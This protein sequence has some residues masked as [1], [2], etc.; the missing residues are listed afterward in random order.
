[1]RVSGG[2]G[3]TACTGG[4][5]RAASGGH[6]SLPRSI[7][8][9]WKKRNGMGRVTKREWIKEWLRGMVCALCTSNSQNPKQGLWQAATGLASKAGCCLFDLLPML[10]SLES[11]R[12]SVTSCIFLAFCD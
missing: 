3:T 7:C 6:K 1:S 10:Q 5:L 11:E 12:R 8:V 4:L 9:L 2:Y